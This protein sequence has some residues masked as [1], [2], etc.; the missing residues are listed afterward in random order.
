MSMCFQILLYI[1]VPSSFKLINHFSLHKLISNLVNFIHTRIWGLFFQWILRHWPYRCNRSSRSA[2]SGRILTLPQ[3]NRSSLAQRNRRL[4][5][6]LILSIKHPII[7]IRIIIRFILSINLL[8]FPILNLQN[9]IFIRITRNLKIQRI[10]PH[11]RFRRIIRRKHH[12]LRRHILHIQITSG[13][14][15]MLSQI[16]LILVNRV[17]MHRIH[18]KN[19]L[20]LL[21]LQHRVNLRQFP[22]RL[23][24]PRMIQNLLNRKPLLIINFEDLLDQV[25]GLLRNCI[26]Q[27]VVPS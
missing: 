3:I 16:F 6:L 5:W 24:H 23:L 22:S 9:S 7:H 17:S 11:I 18:I 2:C 14:Q 13:I 27:L 20:D 15:Q 4:P 10:I 19:L 8:Q 12:R 25:S 1:F 26:R 21:L